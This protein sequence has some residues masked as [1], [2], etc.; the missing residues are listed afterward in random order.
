M[1][2]GIFFTEIIDAKD[3]EKLKENNVDHIVAIYD[4]PSPVLKVSL[5]SF[6]SF[7]ILA[8]CYFI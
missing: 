4:N 6:R 1:I 3:V 8:S 5:S 7:V 2:Y